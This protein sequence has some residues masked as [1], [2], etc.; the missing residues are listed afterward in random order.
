MTGVLPNSE[1]HRIAIDHQ[2]RRVKDALTAGHE[3]S[4]WAE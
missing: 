1:E 2:G 4:H 3:P